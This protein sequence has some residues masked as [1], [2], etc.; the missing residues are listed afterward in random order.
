[1]LNFFNYI[2]PLTIFSNFYFDNKGNGEFEMNSSTT[3]VLLFLL[4]ISLAADIGYNSILSLAAGK[5]NQNQSLSVRS[6]NPFILCPE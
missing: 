1:M 4:I 3:K 5:G 6:A 2:A